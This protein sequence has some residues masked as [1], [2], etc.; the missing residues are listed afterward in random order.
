M[1][2]N[3]LSSASTSRALTSEDFLLGAEAFVDRCVT[4]F[5]VNSETNGLSASERAMLVESLRAGRSRLEIVDVIRQQFVPAFWKTSRPSMNEFE[6]RWSTFVNV[7]LL[8]L[9]APDDDEA[10]VRQVFAQTLGRPP[11]MIEGF[12]GL[13]D[14]KQITRRDFI[15]RIAARSPACRLSSDR[16]DLGPGA[17]LSTSGKRQFRL[18]TAT[19]TGEYLL[20][21]GVW[22]QTAP[23]VDDGLQVSEGF[24]LTGPKLGF[25]P[26][27]WTLGVDLIQP[28]AALLAID[29]VANGGIDR[30]LDVSIA[31]SARMTLAFKIES[32][33][34]FVEVRLLKPAEN[35]MLRRLKI[36]NLVLGQA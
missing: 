29:I 25:E 3:H 18:L 13:F 34:H 14:L 21:P 19:Q 31:G 23:S 6:Q 5:N 22:M 33:H 11:S 24:V 8:E 1:T 27:I 12:E 17:S 35:E 16:A 9:Y 28:D 7:D 26:G 32:W 36:R 2:N 30:L 20:A 15:A 4:A 10:F